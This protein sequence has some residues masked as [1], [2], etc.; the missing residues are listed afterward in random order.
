MVNLTTNLTKKQVMGHYSIQIVK[1]HTKVNGYLMTFMVMVYYL[2]H[3]LIHIIIHIFHTKI[4]NKLI[5]I[6]QN[7]K[8]NSIM[9][10]N[11]DMEN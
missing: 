6:W 2:I 9:I 8:D 11:K 1:S 4:Y 3:I 7:I 10:K 5:N